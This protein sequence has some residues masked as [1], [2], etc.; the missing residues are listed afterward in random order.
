MFWDSLTAAGI[1][2]SVLTLAGAFYLEL[3]NRP[4]LPRQLKNK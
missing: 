4:S 2:V 1:C 3:R